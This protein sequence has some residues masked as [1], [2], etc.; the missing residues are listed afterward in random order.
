MTRTFLSGLLALSMAAGAVIADEAPLSLGAAK[1]AVEDGFYDLAQ[2]QLESFIKKRGRQS[3][4]GLEAVILLARTFWGQGR[5]GAMLTLLGEDPGKQKGGEAGALVY[6]HA[7][8]QYELGN[9]SKALA[10]LKDFEARYPEDPYRLKAVRLGAWCQ[11]RGGRQAEAFKTFSD[12]DRQYGGT[13][14]GLANL[15]DWGQALLADGDLPRARQVL[16]RLVASTLNGPEVQE[17][18]LWLAQVLI[19]EGKWETAWNLLSLLANDATLRVDPRARA[20]LALSEVNAAQTNLEAAV[21]SAAKGVELAPTQLIKNR[22]MALQGRWLIKQGKLNEGAALLRIVIAAAPSDPL[23]GELQLELAGAYYDQNQNEKAVEEYQYYLETFTSLEGKLRALRGRGLA[24]WALKRYAETATVFEKAAGLAKDPDE[25]EQY[26][27]KAADA[28]FANGQFKLAG[29]SYER[30]LKEFPRS[31]RASQVIFQLAES[32]GRQG[33]WARAEERFRT[34]ARRYPDTVLAERALMRLAEMMEE[35]GPN[36]M[37]EALAAYGEVMEVFPGGTLY[38]EALYRHGL[39]SYQ[40][41]QFEAA[42]KDFNRVVDELPASRAAPQAF[43]MRGRSLY[44]MGREEEALGVGRQFIERYPDT[45]WTPGVMFWLGEYAFNHGAYADAEKQFLTLPT[46][47]PKDTLADQALLWAGRAA[48]K[49]KEYL[50][51]T[52]V[53]AR[54]AET[55][56][57]SPRLAEVRFLQGDVLSELGEFSRAIVVFDELIAKF[58]GSPLVSAAWGRKGDCQFTLGAG[59]NK[60]YNEAMKSYRSVVKSPG[61]TI[62]EALQAEYK[63]GRCLDKLGQKAE[64]F[65]QY[66]TRVVAPFLEH[67]EISHEVN[68]AA[69]VWFTKAAFAAADILEADKNWRRAVR[70]LERVVQAGVPAGRDAQERID[71]IRTEH[72]LW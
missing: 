53:F 62:D 52:E 71:R 35:Q 10:E 66:Y 29:E 19:R 34:V 64:A 47:Y 32:L 28:L 60:R 16:E 21:T 58:A 54:L 38:A 36:F 41:L 44:M 11:L 40:L 7:A 27:I 4:E 68:M 17:G 1:A 23:S 42:L 45:E 72:W 22:G 25:R 24:L 9:W 20:W 8:A 15:L 5:Y 49:Q 50:R 37:R 48:M 31:T 57:E 55:Y 65:E 67:G 12:F 3:A 59:D 70:V 46:R 30:V 2:K 14:D 61:V 6:W 26:L 56:P 43:F 51:A 33:E 18:R 69:A 63:I 13:A 39:V